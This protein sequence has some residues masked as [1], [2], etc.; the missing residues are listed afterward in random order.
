MFKYL[1]YAKALKEI[2]TEKKENI[3][4]VVFRNFKNDSK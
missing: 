3:K 1:N 4:T 2:K